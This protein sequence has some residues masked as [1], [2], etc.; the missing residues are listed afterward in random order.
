MPGLG[1]FI[2]TA[3]SEVS[4]AESSHFEGNAGAEVSPDAPGRVG[5][6][7]MEYVDVEEVEE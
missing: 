5:T 7:P 4:D 1:E 3:D 2:A 6:A